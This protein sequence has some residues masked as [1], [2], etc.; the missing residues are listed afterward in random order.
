MAHQ[1]TTCT[2]C[3]VGCGLYLETAGRRV[4]GTYP[5]MS[6]P[7]NQGR[8]C[9]RGW[10]VHEIASSPNRL[11]TPL[12]RENGQLR[13]ATWEEALRFLA[14]RFREIRDRYGPDAWVFFNAPRCAN[15]ESYLL[16][17]L[18]RAVVGTNNIDHGTGVYCNNSIQVLQEMLGVPATTNSIGELAASDVILVDGVDL[19]VQLPTIGGL[20]I[21]AKLAGAKL[22]VIDARR[23]RV[24]EHADHFLQRRPGTDLLVYGAMAKVIVDRGLANHA[25]IKA[26]CRDYAA[27]LDSVRHFD[28]LAAADAAGV[29]AE[30]IE[31]AA[32]TYA[33]GRAAALLYSTGAESRSAESLRALLNLVLLT[34]NLGKEGA[35]VFALTEHNNLQGVC[36]LGVA[37]DRLPGYAP[38]T[39]PA[40]RQRFE[41]AWKCPVPAKPGIGTRDF[42]ENPE[43]S[44]VRAA[45]LCRYDPV[46]TATFCDAA[47]VLR[48]LD[49]VVVQHLF[50]IATS[51]VAHV[52]LPL[53]GFG[54]EEVTFTSTDRRIQL[55][56]QVTEPPIGPVPAW[57]QLT[58]VARA[59]GAPWDYRSSA[60]IMDEICRVVPLY[61]GA[62]H[63]N[64]GRDYGRAW[65]CTKDKPL[66]TRFLF[67]EGIRGR[68]FRFATLARPNAAPAPPAAYPL[69]L[70]FGQSLYYWHQNILVRNSETLHREL[71]VLLMDYPE[72]FV[73]ISVE[74]AQT[75]KIRD[76]SRIQLVAETGSATTCARVTREV[77]AG[78][79]FV[80]F[81]VR[82]LEHQIRGQEYLDH[83]SLGQPVFVRIESA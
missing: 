26:H 60:D 6:H 39:D 69:T 27:F 45:W 76:G 38:V 14:A 55:A 29:P 74:D 25:F 37:P 73:E 12:I 9:V 48:S 51:E 77:R 54:E 18:A 22:I 75:L 1:L 32:L 78:T 23:H 82:E 10:H 24:A 59:L 8:I 15:E 42:F 33:R 46:T 68:P 66:G 70:V 13:P 63:E 47:A 5:S 41:T 56:R 20:V 62:S 36:D 43:R 72:G 30:H 50:P 7:T 31:A 3:G 34:G 21:R 11:R 71:R 81:F 64:L 40:A 16:Q 28:L 83:G 80:P 67:E 17:K 61:S 79:I 52:V 35:G 19:G 57:Q 44:G 4:T 2:F 58:R 49:L 53:V 65:P